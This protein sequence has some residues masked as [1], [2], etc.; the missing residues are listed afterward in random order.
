MSPKTVSDVL[1]E[2]WT[3]NEH[4]EVVRD[5]QLVATVHLRKEESPTLTTWQADP[6]RARIAACAPEALLLL[7]HLAHAFEAE[8]AITVTGPMAGE[9]YDRVHALLTKA[10]V[11]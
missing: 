7:D 3:A 6:L 11:R 5:A 2:V 1:E 9:F 10:G 4:A 8:T